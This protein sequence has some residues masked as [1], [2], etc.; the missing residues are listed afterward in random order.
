MHNKLC[1]LQNNN[2]RG[3]RRLSKRETEHAVDHLGVV[4]QVIEEH[5]SL[6][7]EL[8]KHVKAGAM[9]TKR[10]KVEMRVVRREKVQHEHLIEQ[11]QA[12]GLMLEITSLAGL[13]ELGTHLLK[14]STQKHRN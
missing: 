1:V 9:E 14:L 12:L 4:A 13:K 3:S 11:E 5:S 6:I 7:D 2:S 8:K 10:L